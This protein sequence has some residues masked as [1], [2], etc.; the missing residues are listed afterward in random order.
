MG[1]LEFDDKGDPRMG[2][3]LKKVGVTGDLS[4]ERRVQILQQKV[5]ELLTA[6]QNAGIKT[7]L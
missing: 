6:L 1:V 5:A 3:N 2:D 7:E 4:V